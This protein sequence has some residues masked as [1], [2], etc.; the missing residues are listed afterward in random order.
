[1]IF[2]VIML[3]LGVVGLALAFAIYAEE[4]TVEKRYSSDS[5]MRQDQQG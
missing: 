4:D 1:M 2:G 5:K 3:G